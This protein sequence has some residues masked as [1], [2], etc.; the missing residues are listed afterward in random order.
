LRTKILKIEYWC[1]HLLVT[2]C[3][4]THTHTLMIRV[5]FPCIDC[6]A[7]LFYSLAS[8]LILRHNVTS[9]ATSNL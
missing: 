8:L 9:K 2:S 7:H 4:C 1:F 5:F 3:C 6:C